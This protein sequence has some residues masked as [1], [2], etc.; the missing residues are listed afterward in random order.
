MLR[1]LIG[2]LIVVCVLVI[3]AIVAT[4]F[5]MLEYGRYQAQAE[6]EALVTVERLE[7]IK[8]LVQ[9]IRALKIGDDN[10][11]LL[12]LGDSRLLAI[13]KVTS[14]K[15]II[16][17]LTTG[18]PRKIPLMPS[19]RLDYIKSLIQFGDLRYAELALRL[20]S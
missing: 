7:E 14:N 2:F 9:E 15:I 19:P 13:T 8:A 16:Y 6:W 20:P 10:M 18:K 11:P 17:D 5:V 4:P 12:E 1:K 3:V